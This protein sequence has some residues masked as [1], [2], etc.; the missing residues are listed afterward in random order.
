MTLFKTGGQYPPIDHIERISKYI[1]GRKTYDNRQ[2]E[3]YE[4]AIKLLKDTPHGKQLQSLY[5]GVALADILVTKPADLLVGEP[6]VYESGMPDSSDEQ[7]ALNRIVE[8]ND[9]N[10]LI[11]EMA[12]GTGFRGDGW[13]KVRFDY[14]QDFSALTD[15]GLPIPED[16]EMIPIIEAVNAT[17][18]FPELSQGQS[19]EFKAI[20]V[21]WVEWVETKKTEKPFLNVER[22]LPGY[23]EY[24]RFECEQNEGSVDN[25]FGIPVQILRI[26]EQVSTGREE[27]R[28]ATG[29]PYIL[30]RHIPYKST[31]ESW[32]GKSGLEM[33][34]GMLSAIHDRITQ[35]DYILWKHADP[36]AYGPDLN[37][38]G[39][40]RFGG[41]YIPITKEDPTPGYMTWNAQLDAAFKELDY[42]VGLVFQISE[43][44]Q[45]LF[46][47]TLA[48]NGGGTGT[49]HT[50]SGA[51][52]ARF[53]P[54]L[55][56]VKRIRT[57]FDRAIRDALWLAM[58]IENRQMDG[59]NGFKKYTPVYPKIQWKDGIPRDEKEFAEIMQIRTGGKPT[60]DVLSAVKELEEVDDV[61]ATAIMD[62]IK[63]DEEAVNGTV[64]SS[65]FNGG[66]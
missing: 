21:A 29:K 13:L 19:K 51:I 62:R 1:K 30:V 41:K 57:H 55:S 24:Y 2:W 65:I 26:K 53:M 31:D 5:I 42:L 25:S 58:E 12:I 6:P 48:D 64:D 46:G 11:H 18:V 63:K 17:Y 35:I 16:A 66:N 37:S 10:Q 40:A 49:S 32:E 50:D 61:R 3:V 28:V 15:A 36:T 60:I 44:P 54:I 33:I 7:K 14:K 56:K 8:E 52:K 23:I 27:N 22:H 9:L 38:D 34:D 43:T 4:R 45:W 59:V 47:T 39:V 20:N